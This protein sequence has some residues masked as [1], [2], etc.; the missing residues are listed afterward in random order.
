MA[1]HLP[2]AAVGILDARAKV[3]F[4]LSSRPVP[5]LIAVVPRVV[6]R[7][8]V[9]ENRDAFEQIEAELLDE[10]YMAELHA[11]HSELIA[12]ELRV[13]ELYKNR[14]DEAGPSGGGGGGRR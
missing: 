2:V 9:R 8:L 3:N 12:E 4:P 1:R 5:D 14:T 13:Y 10:A 7:H 6:S 11:N